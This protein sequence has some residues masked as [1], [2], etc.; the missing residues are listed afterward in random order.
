MQLYIQFTFCDDINN[1]AG[2]ICY[3]DYFTLCK[4]AVCMW[5]NLDIIYNQLYIA[6]R[7]YRD[8]LYSIYCIH[9]WT[10]GG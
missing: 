9:E 3:I 10:L 1:Q 6:G 2:K 5:I 4:Y 7:P 8:L